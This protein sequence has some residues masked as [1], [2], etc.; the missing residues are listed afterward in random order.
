MKHS[1]KQ[2]IGYWLNR[3]AH[4]VELGFEQRLAKFGITAAQWS[5][6]VAINNSDAD[7]I[8]KLAKFIEI[9]KGT[10][11]RTV[12][13]LHAKK[14]IVIQQGN[15]RRSTILSLTMTGKKLIQN[16]IKCAL[17]NENFYFG[18]LEISEKQQFKHILHKLITQLPNI[19]ID[20]WIKP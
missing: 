20:G 15:D 12:E 19:T 2:D 4:E 14:L 17:D 16:L 13:R 5:I 1:L 8:T 9:D 18:S 6:L 11:S 3:L 7:S 10:V